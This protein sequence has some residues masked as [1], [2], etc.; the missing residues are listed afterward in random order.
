LLIVLYFSGFS[1]I[2][3]HR[4]KIKTSKPGQVTVD[5]IVIGGIIA[6][7]VFAPLAFGLSHVW[8][9]TLVQIGVFSLGLLYLLDKI[10][11]R[12][13]M[14]W[15]WARTPLDGFIL[16]FLLIGILQT[17]PLPM[18]LV[19]FLSPETATDKAPLLELL[20]RD[21]HPD[22]LFSD[23][24][25]LTYNQH[26][27]GIEWLK[28]ATYT[29]LFF[30]VLN[31]ANTRKRMEVLVVALLMVGC[32][33]AVYAIYQVFSPRPYVWWWP[34]RIGVEGWASGT[35]IGSNHFAGYMELIVFLGFGYLVALREKASQILPEHSTSV[36]GI[37]K[38][39]YQ[40]LSNTSFIQLA[41]FLYISV[42]VGVALLQ[43]A[44][45]GGILAAL[46]TMLLVCLIFITK[47]RY[48]KKAVM[49]SAICL[50]IFAYGYSTGIDRTLAKFKMIEGQFEKRMMETLVAA[51]MIYDYPF[52]GLG[53]GVLPSLY[54]RYAPTALFNELGAGYLHNDWVT[55]GAELGIMGLILVLVGTV[56]FIIRML[57]VWYRRR[58]PFAVGIGAGAVAGIISIGIH[59]YVELNMRVPANPMTLA[60]IAAI[61]YSAVHRY[62]KGRRERFMYRVRRVRLTPLRR[63]I[64]T[65]LIIPVYCLLM[66]A[67]VRHFL[68]E[69]HCATEW[70]S[71]LNL[72]YDPD[73]PD[74]EAA[75]RLNPFNAKYHHKK[76]LHYMKTP[77]ADEKQRRE[78]NE[79]V[80]ESLENALRC[81]PAEA[82][83]WH[84]LGYRY[85]YKNYDSENHSTNWLPAADRCLE[86][87]VRCAPRRPGILYNAA[88]YWVWRS[89]HF[90]ETNKDKH[91]SGVVASNKAAIIKFQE[92]FRNSFEIKTDK[93]KVLTA[94]DQIWNYY[95]NRSAVLGILPA[96]H[97]GLKD[98]VEKYIKNKKM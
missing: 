61:G 27:T 94:V 30:L 64:L 79:H 36:E 5:R 56:F 18:E 26:A 75:I 4:K 86:Q 11:S 67:S 51:P 49:A 21:T 73:L 25:P 10:L 40:Y 90:S 23:W 14:E 29:A 31:T 12:Q 91:R 53:M 39:L 84:D 28:M 54:T 68:A 50:I 85:S 35:F 55:L 95:P 81:N 96:G 15:S 63:L 83:Y 1:S 57:R 52:T 41:L 37:K 71:T 78:I 60:A 47:Q 24:I 92:L 38:K 72:N 34:S 66:T 9:Y 62:R 16:A 44:S 74:I 97:D 13:Q 98:E 76:A 6:L 70:N 19:A 93:K 22:R 7:L 80:I 32:F 82:N 87:A 33:E 58:D 59:S 65:V 48:R 46:V 42:T 69:A 77:A 20:A 89:T 17:V 8:A 2:S 88:W 3:K 45:R 43:S